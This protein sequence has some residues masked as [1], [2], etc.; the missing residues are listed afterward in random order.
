MNQQTKDT[1]AMQEL[2][3]QIENKLD[4]FPDDL[5]PSERG[6][7]D[8]YLNSLNIA[9]ALLQKEIGQIEKAYNQG[10][11][12]ADT[13]LVEGDDIEN[14]SDANIYFTQTYKQ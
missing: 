8:G 13:D 3:E 2:I 4:Q 9:K 11:R 10:Y 5:L 7:Y 1:T 14:Y 6:L 12:D